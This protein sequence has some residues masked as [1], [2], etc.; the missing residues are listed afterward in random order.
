[1]ASITEVKQQIINANSLGISNLS[2]KGVELSESATTYEIMQGI[3]DIITGKSSGG[4]EYKNII[5]NEDD[6]ITLI[7]IYD[8]EHTISYIY[9]DDKL[10][11]VTYDGEPIAL[12]YENK[13]I[14][15]IGETV[16]DF[17]CLVRTY[18]E[19][20]DSGTIIMTTSGVGIITKTNDEKALLVKDSSNSTLFVVSGTEEGAAINKSGTTGSVEY[21]DKTFYY[22][23]FTNLGGVLTTH[24]NFY[25]YDRSSRDV[26]RMVIE[27]LDYY[28]MKSETDF[29]NGFALGFASNGLINPTA[30]DF[31]DVYQDYGNRTNYTYA[32][33][34]QG[35]RDDILKP[36]YPIAPTGANYM[37]Y[38][39]TAVTDVSPIVIDLSACTAAT[40]MFGSAS[41]LK[42]IGVLDFTN[43]ISLWSV[44]SYCSSLETIDKII[45]NAENTYDTTFSGCNK[46]VNITFEGEIAN[47]ISFVNSSLLSAESVQN[48]IDH[49]ATVTT[50]Q[51]IT[52]H[53]AIVLSDEQ[54]A[55]ISSK[56]WTLVQ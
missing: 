39:N 16:I 41:K 21:G 43:F 37:F 49:L 5:Y 23:G 56:G 9:E 27:L 31:W 36:K 53:S 7:D 48:I 42:H 55:T 52:F 4:V 18:M 13:N 51:T 22:S 17:S 19:I 10:I 24:E 15:N 26:E 46:L 2:E 6:T 30:V 50:A 12:T 33:A 45:V 28:F 1:M 34:G 25:I 8:V 14:V 35:W 3:A 38:Y 44:F 40:A 29:Q 54:K 20:Y 47:S 32:F 11:G